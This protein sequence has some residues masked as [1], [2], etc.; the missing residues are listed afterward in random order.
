MP[1][2]KRA[3]LKKAL[4]IAAV[5]LQLPLLWLWMIT[6]DAI[7]LAGYKLDVR[8]DG[9]YEFVL[10]S[11]LLGKAILSYLP[12][13]VALLVC[14]VSSVWGLI[15]FAKRKGEMGILGV[16]LNAASLVACAVLAVAFSCS[17]IPQGTE[18]MTGLRVWSFC[19]ENLGLDC[20]LR[21]M[22]L[23]W[24]VVKYGVFGLYLA[25]SGTL[26]GLGIADVVRSRTAPPLSGDD[27]LYTIQPLPKSKSE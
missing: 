26:C 4:A 6:Y 11:D 23:L 16:C 10:R 14:L 9:G 21:Q 24:G 27:L 2:F 20:T 19:R 7:R 3:M 18:Y 15:L 22:N 25:A 17:V 13:I 5:A 1:N 8:P 12:V